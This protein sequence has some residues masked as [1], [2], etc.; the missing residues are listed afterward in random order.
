MTEERE[1]IDLLL[2]LTPPPIAPP[3][4]LRDRV[5]ETLRRA[6]GGRRRLGDRQARRR[7]RPGVLAT[8][9]AAVMVAAA[10]VVTSAS[11]RRP[12]VMESFTLLGNHAAAATVDVMPASAGMSVV[13]IQVRRL[14][15]TPPHA[16]YQL[17]FSDGSSS[18]QSLTFTTARS[19]TSVWT[20]T[21]SR[22]H[23]RS[24]WVILKRPG[25]PDRRV[26]WMT[27]EASPRRGVEPA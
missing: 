13:A 11:P 27:G 24:C 8:L 22:E 3:E 1:H 23:W 19:P 7:W 4:H 26:L 10:I 14:P 21:S 2:R 17:W 6:N 25:R 16:Q 12:A 18:L 15:P 5:R 9:A 20:T